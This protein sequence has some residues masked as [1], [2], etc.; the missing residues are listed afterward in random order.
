MDLKQMREACEAAK[1]ARDAW[2]QAWENGEPPARASEKRDTTRLI[3]EILIPPD[4][5]LKWLDVVDAARDVPES[6][7]EC[8]TPWLKEA[9]EALEEDK[10]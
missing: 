1:D 6:D 5:A 7:L 10:C 3:M 4:V 9:I 2:H 8:N